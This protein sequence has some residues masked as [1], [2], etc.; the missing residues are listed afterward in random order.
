MARIASER[1]RALVIVLG[2]AMPVFLAPAAARADTE[3]PRDDA[4]RLFSQ[5]SAAFLARKYAEALVDLR[6]SYKLVPSPNSGLLIARC[7]RELNRRVEAV[8]MYGAVAVDARRRAA[9]GDAKYAQTADVAS[10]EGNAVRAT[11]GT[12]RVRV[13]H[14]PPGSQVEIDNAPT[15]VTDAEL[16]VLHPPGDV[17]VKFKPRTGA[18]QSQRATVAAG[19][20]VRMEFTP[21]EMA[22]PPPV[23]PPT[24]RAAPIVPGAPSQGEPPSWALPAALVAGGVAIVGAGVFVGFGLKSDSTY[25]DLAAKCGAEGC[26][27]EDRAVA[28]EGKRDQTIANVGLVVGI[29][30]AASAITFLL[31]RAYAPRSASAM[32]G[33]L[34]GTF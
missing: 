21:A 3:D 34:S 32:A 7:L 5:G 23:E 11:L 22:A 30:G 25:K 17:T 31:L 14:P 16:V 13:A 12:I 10:T 18:E 27:A 9:E 33:G 8:E 24:R 2:C 28:D 20:E 19:A 26:G 6:A 1:L 15:P 29:A 4:K